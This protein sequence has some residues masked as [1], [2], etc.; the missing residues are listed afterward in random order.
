MFYGKL[1]QLFGISQGLGLE[2]DS[3]PVESFLVA[4][5]PELTHPLLTSLDVTHQGRTASTFERLLEHW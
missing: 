2:L 4:Y 5:Y 3:T 1:P